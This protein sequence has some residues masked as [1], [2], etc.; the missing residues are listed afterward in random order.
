MLS[1]LE[2]IVFTVILIL[3]VYGFFYPLYLRYRLIRLG[4][5]EN[6]FDQPLKRMWDAVSSFFFL[7][8]SVKKERVFT[9]LVH[10]FILYGSLTFDTVSVYHIIQGFAPGAHLTPIH[11][12]I[13]DMFG[14][15]VLAAVS[16]FIYRRYILKPKSYTYPSR[17]SAV[18]YALLI[19]VT[20]T[21]NSTG[22][23]PVSMKNLRET[24]S[25]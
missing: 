5:S 12:L 16:Y 21:C 9:G 11:G 24:T 17:E 1:L 2:I 10:I 8:C 22:G 23:Q 7:R 6:R 19:T 4:K 20:I 15:M 13:A 3:T 14:V 25:L 18:I